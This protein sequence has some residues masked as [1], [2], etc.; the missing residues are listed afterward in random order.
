MNHF[1]IS[2]GGN[3]RREFKYIENHLSLDNKIN[4]IETFCGS[5][6]ISFNI[7]LKHGNKFNYYL[8]DLDDDLFKIYEVIKN[9]DINELYDKLNSIISISN[10][11]E[12]FKEMVKLYKNDN[13]IYKRIA[14]LQLAFRSNSLRGI[15]SKSLNKNNIKATKQKSLFFDFIKSPNVFITNDDWYD[16]YN[17]HKDDNQS[18]FIFDPPYINSDNIHFY[19]KT[20]RNLNIYDKL[21]EI[22]NDKASSIFIIEKIDKIEELFKNWNILIEYDKMYAIKQRKTKHIVYSN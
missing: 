22:K 19:K 18:L 21:D 17:R 3:K 1:I 11:K 8:N 14:L 9:D 12:T 10:T 20:C 7:W 2:W 5:S 6:A 15:D 13:D 16:C 4:I